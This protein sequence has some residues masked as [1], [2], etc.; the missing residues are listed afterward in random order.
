MPVLPV[1][2]PPTAE[3]SRP[4]LNRT[5]S[6]LGSLKAS[7]LLPPKPQQTAAARADAVPSPVAPASRADA[8][9]ETRLPDGLVAR[10]GG[11]VSAKVSEKLAV[12]AARGPEYEAIAR[13]S[14]E[15]IEQVVWEVVPEL[16][17]IIIREH[18]ERLAAVRK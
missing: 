17:E 6:G 11:E 3:A 12:L 8:T 16:A 13:L 1:P 4:A 15:V 7:D 5:L 18:V 2:D 10:V 14:R 9:A